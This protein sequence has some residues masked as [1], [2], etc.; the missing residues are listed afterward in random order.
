MTQPFDITGKVILIT[1]SQGFLGQRF[2]AGLRAAGATVMTSDIAS[3]ADVTLD[4]RDKKSIAAAFDEVLAR[5]QRVDVVINNAAIDPKFDA[6]VDQNTKL[7]ENYPQELL[8]QSLD[9]NL[10]GYTLV[11]QEAVTRMLE[12]GSG[13]IINISS[14]Y[15]LVGPD[16]RMYPKGAQKPVEYAITKGGVRMLTKW[17]ATSYGDRGIRANTYTLGGVFKEHDKDFQENYGARTP[18]GRMAK[19]EEVAGPLVFLVSDAASYMTGS[20]LVADGGWT[21]W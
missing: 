3:G 10:L 7:F 15:G 2:V 1:G 18:L 16:Q 13:H 9:V 19:P 6:G 21:A 5:H 8:E 12:Q 20:E 14:I 4:V 11:A 17:L